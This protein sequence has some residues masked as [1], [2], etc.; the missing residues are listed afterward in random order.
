MAHLSWYTGSSTTNTWVYDYS[1][2]FLGAPMPGAELNL[3]TAVPKAEDLAD[4]TCRWYE[5][6]NMPVTITATNTVAIGTTLTV[7]AGDFAKAGVKAGTLLRCVTLLASGAV[8]RETI[9]VTS[10]DS[11]TSA[12][13]SRDYGESAMSESVPAT[14][15]FMVLGN[16]ND[17]GSVVSTATSTLGKNR[18]EKTNPT[19]IMDTFLRLSGTDLQ[20]RY[21]GV[22]SNWDYQ[23]EAVMRKFNRE[24]ERHLVHSRAVARD[25]SNSGSMGGIID[26]I[27]EYGDATAGTGNINASFGVF[28]YENV[29]DAIKIMYNAGTAEEGLTLVGPVNMV[30]GA[31]YMQADS[32]RGQYLGELTRGLQTTAIKSTTGITVPLIPCAHWPADSFALLNFNK[33]RVRFLRAL[34]GYDMPLGM[35][36][37]D[38]Q[39]RRLLTEMSVEIRDVANFGHYFARG[40]TSWGRPS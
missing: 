39:A 25:A 31:A 38:F 36:G 7:T 30:Q 21:R 37:Q 24:L 15:T 13:I 40:I 10:I 35:M 22:A 29:D 14:A 2:L 17:E 12:T 5:D 32:Q 3:W 18:V 23:F 20:R 8:A 26:K 19:S 6:T 27:E 28:N 34:R 16:L 1:P 11:T 33:I 4:I 9:L